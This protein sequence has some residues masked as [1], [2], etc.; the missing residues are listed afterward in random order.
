MSKNKDYIVQIIIVIIGV[1]GTISAVVIMNW[2]KI[3]F[4]ESS[5]PTTTPSLKH[6]LTL[7]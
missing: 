4:V 3:P 7:K 1:V 5:A 2:D 6:L